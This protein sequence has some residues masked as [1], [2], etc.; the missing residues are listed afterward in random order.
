MDTHQTVWNEKAAKD[1]IGHLEKRR[2]EG[3]YA[4]TADQARDEILSMIPKRS[5][6]FSLR[7]HDGSG[8]GSLGGD[9]RVA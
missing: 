8:D 9:S 1:I 4:L 6:C 2:M 5:H 3:S 7:V